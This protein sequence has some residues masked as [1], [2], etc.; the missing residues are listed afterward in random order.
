METLELMLLAK[1]KQTSV[2]HDKKIAEL[3]KKMAE[4]EE[5]VTEH[6]RKITEQETK[7]AEQ[8]ERITEQERK[9]TEQEEKI[10]DQE[11]KMTEI[12]KDLN[13]VRLWVTAR[14]PGLKSFL[15]NAT[16][17]SFHYHLFPTKSYL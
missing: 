14:H 4:Q 17:F 16:I 7:I 9:V 15:G 5:K 8:E 2:M 10:A 3:E 12:V 1:F 11:R 6:E 13:L